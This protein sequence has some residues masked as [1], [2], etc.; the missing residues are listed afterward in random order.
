MTSG[1]R[2]TFRRFASSKGRSSRNVCFGVAFG[3]IL[4]LV[5]A[6]LPSAARAGDDG[7]AERLVSLGAT[8]EVP[9]LGSG[10]RGRWVSAWG[11]SPRDIAPSLWLANP[12]IA[13][14]PTRSDA[15][16]R[17]IITSGVSGNSLRL[18]FSNP[19]G[20]EVILERVTVAAVAAPDGDPTPAVAS[21]TLRQVRFS[22]ERSVTLPV[23]G[24]ELSDP[25]EMPVRRGQRLAVSVYVPGSV[26]PS[27]HS[28]TYV[29]QFVSL[30]GS[31]D[32]TSELTALSFVD[33]Q[34]P[35]H[36]LDDL[37]VRRKGGRSIV[38]IG[39]S[40][41]DGEQGPPYH[42]DNGMNRFVTWPQF[43]KKRLDRRH[44]RGVAV[45]NAGVNGDTTDGVAA[46]LGPDVLQRKGASLAVVE[47][48]TNDLTAG[49]SASDVI[50]RLRSIADR[51]HRHG[52]RVVGA[53][54]APR[55]ELAYN[56]ESASQ[57]RVVINRWIRR[58]TTFDG[59]LDIARVVG[60]GRH[61]DNM[62]DE[63]DGGD[64]LHP[65]VAGYKAI[66]ASFD[67]RALGSTNSRD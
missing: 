9:V 1:E 56:T 16:Y 6:P 50:E 47:V 59:V 28:Q 34:E 57:H 23:G 3:L 22:T 40:I 65:N 2:F 43:L 7:S 14:A 19:E 55:A 49:A 52:I 24:V 32:R 45:I 60:E 61:H 4:A 39:D 12:T 18:R 53:T 33:R 15:T 62:K 26:R 51:L 25:V 17:F 48:G 35:I 31:G 63:F 13:G 21:G 66:A 44:R 42:D 67:L 27:S 10:G 29:T 38:L 41:T 46:R 5:D 54:L 11:Q 58:S 37:H 30:P 64:G 36:W 20:D 8:R